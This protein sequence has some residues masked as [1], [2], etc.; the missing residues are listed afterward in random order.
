MNE[1]RPPANTA[2]EDALFAFGDDPNA[3][4]SNDLEATIRRLQRTTGLDAATASSIPTDL[5][6]QIWEDLMHTHAAPAVPAAHSTSRRAA[7]PSLRGIISAH[8]PLTSS[9]PHAHHSRLVRA[10]IRWQPAV[11]LAIVIAFLLGLIGVAY[12]RGILDNPEP[13]PTASGQAIPD[14]YNP[15]ETPVVSDDC[16]PHGPRRLTN[17]ELE[18]MRLDDWQNPIYVPAGPVP[19]EIGEAAL[20]TYLG[21]FMCEREFYYEGGTPDV[22]ASEHMLSFYSDRW[23]YMTLAPSFADP[24]EDE[25]A[26]YWRDNEADIEEIVAGFPLPL[27]RTS[28]YIL[29]GTSV[30]YPGFQPGDVYR[31]PDDRYGVVYGTI[32]TEM[33]QTG[34]PTDFNDGY[35]WF[36]AFEE[37]DGALYIDEHFPFCVGDKTR[38]LNEDGTVAMPGA[39]SAS[40]AEEVTLACR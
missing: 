14:D 11:S 4:P 24:R 27:N 12:Q 7:V 26:Q 8:A 20:D 39:N 31:L 23:Q 5:K 13:T 28:S 2:E 36:L 34:Q 10:V 16:V 3:S 15:R 33:M 21:W 9:S 22:H 6:H 37:Y 25:I 38:L 1:P 40:E 30:H 32:T 19:A 35:L 18:A 17:A 29:E